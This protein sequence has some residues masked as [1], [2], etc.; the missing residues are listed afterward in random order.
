[1]GAVPAPAPSPS[2]T[3]AP[4]TVRPRAASCGRPADDPRCAGCAQ[5]GTFRALRRAGLAVRGGLGCDPGARRTVPSPGARWAEVTGARR[6]RGAAAHG[7][8]GAA[9]RDGASLVVVGDIGDAARAL[10]VAGALR[11]AGARALVVDPSDLPAIED[12][13]ARASRGAELVALV[14][15]APCVRGDPHRPALRVA[16]S[17]CNRCGACVGLA[18]PAIRDDGGEAVLIDPD[19]C[20]GCGLCAPLCR[21][22]A[23]VGA[24]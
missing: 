23:I 3:V 15:L 14:A 5:L 17:R 22:V 13:V 10:R 24:A 18:C 11:A 1:M 9:T 19:V 4:A 7:L 16:A 2:P 21:G 20:S 12:V 8:V 6:V